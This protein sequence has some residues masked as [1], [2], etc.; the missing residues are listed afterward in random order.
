MK[1][2][3]QP[4]PS[5][6][7]TKAG[8]DADAEEGES[9]SG[10]RRDMYWLPWSWRMLRPAAHAFATP[11]KRAAHALADRLQ[12]LVARAVEAAWMPTHSAE[13]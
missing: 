13:Q 4:L 12:G 11:P 7:R 2:S 9:P 10:S 1:R 5:G 6:A 8:E 3:A